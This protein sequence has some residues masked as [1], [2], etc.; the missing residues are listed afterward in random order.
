M[1]EQ[2]KRS[3]KSWRR[4][5]FGGRSWNQE[6]RKVSGHEVRRGEDRWVKV[7]YFVKGLQLAGVTVRELHVVEVPLCSLNVLSGSH[8]VVP[9]FRGDAVPDLQVSAGRETVQRLA[10]IKRCVEDYGRGGVEAKFLV[11]RVCYLSVPNL[12]VSVGR[13]G[14]RK[15]A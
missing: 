14:C 10:R 7:T 9:R 12:L 15:G 13:R 2:N 4:G 6:R 8:Q 3:R 11:C 5:I 1:N